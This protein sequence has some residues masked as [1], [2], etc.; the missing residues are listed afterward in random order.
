MATGLKTTTGLMVAVFAV[1]GLA[2]LAKP[3]E[4]RAGKSCPKNWVMGI[5][6]CQPGFMKAKEK[7]QPAAPKRALKR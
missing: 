4:A 6:G 1:V 5:H 7:G 2:V 3:A